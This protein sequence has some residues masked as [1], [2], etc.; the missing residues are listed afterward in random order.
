MKRARNKSLRVGVIGDFHGSHKRPALDLFIE[1]AQPE[2]LLTVGDLQYYESWPLPTTFVRGNHE[3]WDIIEGLEKGTLQ[4]SNLSYLADGRRA[5]VN[6]LSVA[7]MGGNWSPNGKQAPKY[8]RHDYLARFADS[9]ADIVLSHETPMR[10]SDGLHDHLTLE[11]MREVALRVRP[12]LWF[13]GHHHHYDVEQIDARTTFISLGKWPH[14]W[15]VMD[16][17]P[18]KIENW[19]RFEPADLAAYHA[20]KVLWHLAEEEQKRELLSLE[21]G[22]RKRR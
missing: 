3:D 21:R 8:I 15:V 20:D 4:V 9:R 17:T 22:G 7:G 11:P 10:P 19:H 13:S 2:L 12:Q 14:E 18:G 1:E 16:L 5:T 6:G